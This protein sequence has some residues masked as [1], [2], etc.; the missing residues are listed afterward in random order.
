MNTRKTWLALLA[1]AIIGGYAY[2]SSLQPEPSKNHKVF[3]LKPA[4]IERI[5]LKGPAHDV[6]VERGKPGLWRIVKPVEADADN[7]SAD[8]LASALADLQTT[9]TVDSNP[10]DLGNFGLAD[11]SV[12]VYITTNTGR[13]LPGVMV[14]KNTPVGASTYIKLTDSPAVMLTDAGFSAEATKSLDDLRS[15]TLIGFTANQINRVVLTK[16]DGS[17]I[18]LARKG[19][20]WSIVKPRE[21]PADSAAVTQ[22]LDT[23]AAARVD[24]FV[25]DHPE[26]L[27]RFG[28]ATPSLKLQVFGG[29]DNAEES[30]LFGF[31]QS[32]AYA[33]AVYVRRGEGDQPVCTVAEY[34]VKELSKSYDDL[35]DKTVLRFDPK[36]VARISIAGGPVQ[37][38]IASAGKDKW[39]V[40][41]GGHTVPAETPVVQSLLDQLQQLKGSS[42]VEDPMT[43][44]A[45]FGMAEPTLTITLYD[46]AGKTIGVI[47]AS[48]V[49]ETATPQNPSAKPVAQTKGY[50]TS[51]AD[52]A[53]YEIPTAMV[54]DLETT[55]TRLHNDAEP[56]PSPS[57]A[58]ASH[59]GSPAPT[60]AAT[61]PA[62]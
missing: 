54:R 22:L 16:S 61:P 32:K 47:H 43:D 58:A 28:L 33:N 30:L 62:Q 6:V 21:Y 44:P 25:D 38:V 1:L 59:A 50:A 13:T 51:S 18:E 14:G 24:Q 4:Q 10:Q 11:P 26:D 40:T 55:A 17:T 41:G 8:A 46:A 12:T 7:S 57:P 48:Q 27:N 49:E 52:Q 37:I 23:I 15:K 29:K 20:N 3:Q 9:E 39:T 19:E 34:V 36:N 45:R 31:E 42:I 5:E 53:V 56:P 60:G 35:R 2:Y